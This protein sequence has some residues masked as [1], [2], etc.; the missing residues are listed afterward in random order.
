MSDVPSVYIHFDHTDYSDHVDLR[1]VTRT[2]DGASSTTWEQFPVPSSSHELS[3][4]MEYTNSH[5]SV[6]IF[7]EDT[8]DELYSAGLSSDIPDTSNAEHFGWS[9]L[10]HGGGIWDYDSGDNALIWGNTQ[11]NGGVEFKTSEWSIYGSLTLDPG[12]SASIPV[13]VTIPDDAGGVTNTVTLTATSQTDSSVSD[14]D[15][16]DVT[17][18]KNMEIWADDDQISATGHP[19]DTVEMEDNTVYYEANVEIDIIV[20]PDSSFGD[21]GVENLYVRGGD[22]SD[23][24]SFQSTSD[25]KT[26]ISNEN[27][28]GDSKEFDV[29][30]QV[31]IP[32]GTSAGE[33]S[34]TVVYEIGESGTLLSPSSTSSTSSGEEIDE[35]STVPREL[36]FE[37]DG[38]GTLF[39]PD[40]DADGDGDA[41]SDADTCPATDEGLASILEDKVPAAIPIRVV[42]L[43]ILATV[44][45][46]A[47][48]KIMEKKQRDRG[49]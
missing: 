21:I 45:A 44:F 20:S 46:V 36:S 16:M 18:E 42:Y 19:G 23:Y 1:T 38:A 28:G 15:S 34:V 48:R 24:E 33:Y 22:V 6:E 11:G 37:L 2:S 47:T 4:T 5:F 29:D 25:S 40:S 13:D 41:V 3:I 10:N 17:L 49:S 35:R 39:D 26:L 8:N 12:E 43:T 32:Y 31:Y 7:N 9:M 27:P 30:W 14:S